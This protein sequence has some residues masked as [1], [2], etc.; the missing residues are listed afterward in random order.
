MRT[1]KTDDNKESDWLW[2]RRRIDLTRGNLLT[3]YALRQFTQHAS[4][5]LNI[6]RFVI[7]LVMPTAHRSY[8][9]FFADDFIYARKYL[10]FLRMQRDYRARRWSILSTG[11]E[12]IHSNSRSAETKPFRMI[13]FI[14]C[15][16]LESVFGD[17][18]IT[19]ASRIDDNDVIVRF[20]VGTT[21]VLFSPSR[22]SLQ[23]CIDN[24]K[25]SVLVIYAFVVRR[26]RKKR[27][28]K[29]AGNW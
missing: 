8:S 29:R 2:I 9:H 14:L 15:V 4:R 21:P 24:G 22:I 25:T 18:A 6:L 13:L 23:L 5:V 1:R 7:T 27:E 17:N 19:L 16:I 3:G 12:G 10:Y 28:R 26:E 20:I 11:I